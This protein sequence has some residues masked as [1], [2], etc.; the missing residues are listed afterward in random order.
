MRHLAV[1]WGAIEL[2]GKSGWLL[3]PARTNRPIKAGQVVKVQTQTRLM[4]CRWQSTS[5]S[6]LI[7]KSPIPMPWV[8]ESGKASSHTSTSWLDGKLIGFEGA[9]SA[10]A[11]RTSFTNRSAAA[12]RSA[13]FF[14]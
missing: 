14:T 3:D 12:R 7:D 6:F 13:Q 4:R 2:P 9:S 1:V 5:H 11:P 8:A 10:S